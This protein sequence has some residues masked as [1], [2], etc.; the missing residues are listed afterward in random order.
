MGS[1][2]ERFFVPAPGIWLAYLVGLLAAVAWDQEVYGDLGLA[3]IYVLM[4]ISLGM[5]YPLLHEA[6]TAPFVLRKGI[7]RAATRADKFREEFQR[8]EGQF[9]ALVGYL[10]SLDHGGRWLPGVA[11]S[12]AFF[13]AFLAWGLIA[14]NI[15]ALTGTEDGLLNFIVFYGVHLG[16]VFGMQRIYRRATHR[17]TTDA[18]QKGYPFLESKPA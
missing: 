1:A 16:S 12:V 7:L 2:W 4:I 18:V 14:L 6:W 11:M 5:T 8:R 15:P 9:R 3:N 13:L 17:F 10:D